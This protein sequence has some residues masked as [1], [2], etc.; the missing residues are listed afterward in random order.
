MK[1][2]LS[3]VD[4]VI[5]IVDARAPLMSRNPKLL[6]WLNHRPHIVLANKADLASPAGNRQWRRWFEEHDE[7]VD[8]VEAWRLRNPVPLAERWKALIEQKRKERGA[9]RPLL[10][11]FRV[12]IVGIPNIG[13]STLINH[14]KS[15]NV[16]KVGPKPGVTRQNQW[17]TIAA[18]LELLDTPGILWPSLRDPVQE[19]MLTLL[20]NIPDEAGDPVRTASFLIRRLAMLGIPAP[21]D[22]LDLTGDFTEPEEALEALAVRRGMLLPGG[23]PSITVAAQAFLK[24]YRSGRLGRWTLENIPAPGETAAAAPEEGEE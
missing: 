20:G 21:W 8:F 2:S 22:K 12:M 10:R 6:Q 5:Q 17:V 16:T 15:R 14:L 1:E 19:Q 18:G 9:T 23:V 4:L 13:K 24:D 7:P 3:L 11:P